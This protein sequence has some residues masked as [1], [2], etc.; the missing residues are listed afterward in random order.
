[1]IKYN[2]Y[3][4][5]LCIFLVCSCSSTL[6]KRK[7]SQ[8]IYIEVMNK[9]YENALEI[10]NNNSFYSEDTSKLLK[11]LELG[12]IN[13][14]NNNYYQ[15]LKNFE[16]AKKI[17]D[18]L[19]T[20]SISKKAL[21]TWDAN[22]DIYYGEVYE[23]S[24]IR[25]YISLI[26]YNLYQQGFY[27][28]YKDDNG[29][30][31]PR[32]ELT[33]KEKIFHLNYAKTSVI[34]W[35]SFL[36]TIQNEKYGEST[37]KDDMLAKLWGA[38]VHSQ[39]NFKNDDQIALN[40]YNNANDILLK[41][42]NMYSIYNEKS[43]EFNKDYKNLPTLSYQQLYKNYIKET[44]YSKELQDYIKRNK[45]NL[46]KKQKDNLIVLIK[47]NL[48]SP[49]TAKTIEIPF[50]ITSF[51]PMGSPAYEFTRMVMTTKEGMPYIL[52]EVPVIEINTAINKYTINVYD[53]QN[54]YIATTNLTLVE[55]LSYIAKQELENNIISIQSKIISRIIAKYITALAS[56][57][58]LYNQE[59]S[60][61]Q[62][63]ALLSFKASSEIINQTSLADL[64]YWITL[65]SNIQ[66]GGI[67][68]NNGEY[69]VQIIL[70]NKDIIYQDFIK[71]NNNTKFIDLNI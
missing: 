38:F 54:N 12:T 11:F 71:I 49:K 66:I 51:G 22:L 16:K 55:P 61:S 3:F 33:E 10:V 69:K 20:I 18:D 30:I 19:Y 62:V 67:K 24:L 58:A 6:D 1:M 41:N 43:N 2:K 37:Y 59:D 53:L 27:E 47:Q 28:G 32:K 13:Y 64:R 35:N 31:V 68:L 8:S 56:S 65:A 50:P 7:T 52:V 63:T 4:V 39:F 44:K 14:L 25:F 29:N 36:E 5:I 45:K 34:E 23:A 9:N 21:S 17:S 15:A 42:Y 26:N 70:N 60:L 57:Y 40:L 48:I 46:E